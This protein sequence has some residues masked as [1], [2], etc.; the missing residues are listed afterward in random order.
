MSVFSP[1]PS[2][3]KGTFLYGLSDAVVLTVS[4]S[5]RVDFLALSDTRS[6]YGCP[7]K[8]TKMGTN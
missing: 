8:D 4:V 2:N 7:D 3:A 5:D 6:I 1:G